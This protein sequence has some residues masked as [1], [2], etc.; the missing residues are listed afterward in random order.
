MPDSLATLF[1]R[2]DRGH[3]SRRHLL[4]ALG[5]AIAARPVSALAQGQ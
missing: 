1:E 4:M 2:F 3:L 5:A